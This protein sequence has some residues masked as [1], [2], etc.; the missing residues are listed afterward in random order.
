MN[1][2]FQLVA[3]SDGVF[4]KVFAPTDGGTPVTTPMVLEYLDKQKLKGESVIV[5]KA[6]RASDG[7]PV[8]LSSDKVHPICETYRLTVSDDKMSATA[9]FYPPME[10]AQSMDAEELLGDLKL[11]KILFGIKKDNIKAYFDHRQYCTEIEIARGKD[12]RHGSDAEIGYHFNTDL[13]AKPTMNADGTVDYFHL[14]LINHCQ[15]GDEL[16]TLTPEDPGDNGMNIY[17]DPVRPRKVRVLVLHPGKNTR[18]SEDKQ[19]L[20]ATKTGHVIMEGDHVSVS[21]VMSVENVDTSTGNIEYDGSVEVKGVV[22]SN[23]E[24]KCKGNIVVKGIVEGAVIEAGGDVI[25]ERGINGM[26]HGVIKAG[27]NIITKFI[28]NAE[29]NATGSITAESIIQGRV[30]AG[31]SIDVSGKRG[32]ITAGHVTATEQISAKT[33]GSEMGTTTIVEVGVNPGLR[34]QIKDVEQEIATATKNLQTIEPTVAGFTDKLRKGFKPTPDQMSYVKKLSETAK[35]LHKQLEEKNKEIEELS[36][37]LQDVKKASVK[38][39]GTAYPGVQIM[40][41]SLSQTLKKEYKYGKFFSDG[42]DVRYT[43][44]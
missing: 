8:R 36:A 13:H 29:V 16:A 19:H 6:V 21:D 42:G 26:G 3:N 20:F 30:T 37:Q 25:L 23:F 24:V 27:R 4:L 35:I 15:D 32:N 7:Q 5:D 38:F 41:G 11:K 9:F 18:L 22:S 39:T 17:A 28:E 34:A 31:T 10:G 40:I 33:I 1:G 43:A 12:P 2:Y 44:L 14:N